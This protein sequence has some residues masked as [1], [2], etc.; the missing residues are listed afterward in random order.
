MII[1]LLATYIHNI[2]PFLIHFP[3]SWPINGIRWYGLSYAIGFFIAFL[4]LKHYQKYH[5][6]PLKAGEEHTLLTYLIFGILLGGRIGYGLLY[7]FHHTI[8]APW[9]LFIPTNGG[10]AGMASHGGFI[11]AG[12]AMVLFSYY[13]KHNIWRI[14][15]LIVTLTPPGLFL[16]RI[17]NFINGELWGKITQM[18]WGV[19]FPQSAPPY[20]P[21]SLIP[22][23]HPSQL[24]EATLEG[25]CLGFYLQWRFWK[26]SPS[27]GKLTAEFLILYA[28][29]RIIGE[30]F[31]EPDAPLI[32]QLNRG[33]IYSCI[34]GFLGLVFYMISYKTNLTHDKF[35]K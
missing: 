11:G 34:M 24:Y 31:R 3:T 23:R 6:S 2:D 7:D 12:I 10:I 35:K 15:D 14:S 28:F 16:G 29:L 18:P 21:L 33:I 1:S 26:H 17:A 25:L 32:F 20:C 13:H 27:P 9:S 4:L 5:K 19:I 30:C 22:A 8:T